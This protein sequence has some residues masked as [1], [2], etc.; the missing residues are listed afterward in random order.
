MTVQACP[1]CRSSELGKGKQNE[2]AY[3][4]PVG[5]MSFGSEIEHLICTSC[6]Y[7][8]ESYVKNPKKFKGTMKS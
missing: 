7:I 8:I 5:K 2:Y 4:F 3:M 6:G 1:K